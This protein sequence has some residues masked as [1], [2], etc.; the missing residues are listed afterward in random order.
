MR[1]DNISQQSSLI[2][3]LKVIFNREFLDEETR[4]NSIIE[5]IKMVKNL[6]DFL[7]KKLSLVE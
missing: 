6:K 4:E 5:I 1:D 2:G 7:H 3:E